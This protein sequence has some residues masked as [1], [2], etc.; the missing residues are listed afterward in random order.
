M[1]PDYGHVNA[2]DELS[3]STSENEPVPQPPTPDVEMP[4][5]IPMTIRRNRRY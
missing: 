2:N 3:I 4:E 1:E 5:E